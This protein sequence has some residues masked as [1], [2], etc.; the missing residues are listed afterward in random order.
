MGNFKQLFIKD[1]VGKARSLLCKGFLSMVFA[2]FAVPAFAQ[3]LIS[4]T[5]KNID[6]EPLPG[7]TVRVKGK[8]I[9]ATS[10]DR[11]GNYR[12]SVPSGNQTLIFSSIGFQEQELSIRG[13]AVINVVLEA[14]STL[15]D[16]VVVVGYGK[17]SRQTITT[18]ISKLDTR[19]LEN[20]PY[21][22]AASAL[23]G[24]LPGVRVQATTGQP[25]AAPRIIVRGGTSINNPNGAAPLYIVD[26]VFRN[27]MDDINS[28]DIESIQVLKDAAATAIYGARASNGVVIIVTK[29]G[30]SG[31]IAIQYG[32]DL[33]LSSMD[34][35]YKPL[36]AKD[37]VYFQR[38]G[39]ANTGERSPA[40]LIRLSD[41]TSVGTGNNLSN[42]TAYTTQYLTP[43]N[44]YKLNEGWE[45]VPDP[46]DPS[47]TIIFKNTDWQDILFRTGVSHNH[48][49]AVSGGS[50]RATF[51]TS[52]GYLSDEGIAISTGYK[53]LTFNI[54]GNIKVKDNLDIYSRLMYSNSSNTG[55]SGQ[56]IFLWA[57][58]LAPTAK[59]RLE[60]GSL[61]PGP[62]ASSGNPEYILGK[63]N[64][65]NSTDNL[66]LIIG[67]KWQILP[68]LVF[69]PQISRSIYTA[70][71]RSFTQ[72]YLSGPT[73]LVDNRSASGSHSKRLQHQADAVF[74]YDNTFS[75]SHNLE[76][77]LG[78][79]YFETMNE[80]LSA[81]GRKAASDL[82]PTLNAAAE[83]VAISGQESKQIVA[84]YFAR[85]NYN[86]NQKYLI[87]LNGRYDGASNL[88]NNYKW[89]FFPGLSAGWN[90][91]KE[92]F[93]QALPQSLSSLKIRAS[94]GVNGNISGLGPY[95]AGGQYSVGAR[96]GG[97]PAIV[98]SILANPDLQWEQ[99]K[100]FD[101]GTDIGLLS[102]RINIMF[103]YYRRVTDN[104]I[105]SLTLPHSTG[106]AAIATNLGSLENRGLELD[107]SANLLPSTSPV[108][109]DISFNAAKV[110]SKVL[111]LPN[112]GAENNRIGGIYVWDPALGDYAWLGGIQEGSPVGDLYAYK[113]VSIYATDEEAAK[114]P[115]DMLVPGT[116]K[117]KY[118][119]DVNWFDADG[120]G[121][122]DERDRV[123]M[124]NTY[125]VWTGGFAN[126]VSYRNF[127]LSLRMDYTTGH[128]V[129][130]YRR[131]STVTQMSGD[132]NLSQEVLRS[133]Q[134]QGD[135]TDIPKLYWADRHA[136]NISRGNSEYYERGDFLSLR[137]VT[138]AYTFPATW[139]KKI[140]MTNIR[141]NITGHNLHYFTNYK[142]VIPEDGDQDMGRYPM[143]RNIIFGLKANF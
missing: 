72:A 132:Q 128:T 122:I 66:T 133:W 28:D 63:I 32:Y 78:F 59:Y 41:A 105:T 26:G 58:G 98:N 27:G 21:S 104:L 20:I 113:Q 71:S 136:A 117:T 108:K 143:P 68:N 91:H 55:T 37:F 101:I 12:I 65:K 42:Q 69:E 7:V 29:S 88:G 61:S 111:K 3:T 102:G 2:V 80:S 57:M 127:S 77:K 43:E 83:M 135:I 100:T 99:S 140:G 107:I 123:Y 17:Q 16:D 82:I 33:S 22:N 86:F 9:S 110:K 36:S 109:W 131:A 130:N 106:F 4:G 115:T 51:N 87:S 64:S 70:D 124:G 92:D 13:R 56:N 15:L 134:K 81:S 40:D 74:T 141:L 5:V 54:N 79:A 142:G 94:Y 24:T 116:D 34:I 50:E 139:T 73:T 118:G 53:R 31:R 137:E 18:S 90:V 10:T 45:S 76:A 114:G 47:K 112:N 125:P 119:G 120:N 89:G 8:S 75:R 38:L 23:Q 48:N 60:D 6:G 39:I 1:P 138:V 62:S 35:G 126:A 46:V 85:V 103:D 95:Q 67:S 25:G 11:E 121:I 19:V 44:Q 52:L 96:Y 93:W 84:G 97:S 49:I 30:K 129:F 14:R